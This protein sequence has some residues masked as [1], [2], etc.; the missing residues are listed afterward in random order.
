MNSAKSTKSNAVPALD[1]LSDIY[2]RMDAVADM[3]DVIREECVVDGRICNAVY[4]V[5]CLV[6]S[7]ADDINAY[8]LELKKEATA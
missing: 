5:E 1:K 3:L 7:I 4:G 2:G 6:K 8:R